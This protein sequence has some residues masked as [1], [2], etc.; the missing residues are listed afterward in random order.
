MDSAAAVLAIL[1]KLQSLGFCADLRIPDAAAA[2]DPSEAFDAVLAT[3]LREAY[4]GGREARPIPVALSDGRCVDLLR[5]FLAVRAAGGYA[6]VPNSP[7]GWAAA[8]EAAGVDPALAAPVK[9]VYAKY[10]GALDRWIQRLVEAH[11]PFLDVDMKKKKQELFFGA[12]GVEEEEEGLLNCNGR[13]QR[14]VML[15]RKRGDVVGML[16]WVRE[17]AENA[18]NGVAVAAGS[19]DEYFS[20]ALAVREMVTGKRARRASMLNGSLFQVISI[21]LKSLLAKRFTV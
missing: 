9:L 7:G 20:M 19:L 5:L 16:G 8:A 15:K 3:F 2:S 1:S 12:N 21:P 18:G 4:T 14:H 10:L 6:G 11:G 13:E 17:I